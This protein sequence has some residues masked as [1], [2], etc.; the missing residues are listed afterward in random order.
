[1]ASPPA[2][3]LPVTYFPTPADL[4]SWFEEHHATVPELWIGFYNKAS[5]RGGIAYLE[6]LEEALCFGWIDGIKKKVDAASFTLRFTPRKPRSPWSASNLQR[7]EELLRAERIRPP[8]LAAFERRDRNAAPPPA[9]TELAPPYAAKLAENEAA[10]RFF[11]AQPPGYRKNAS[12]WVMSAKKEETRWKRLA[13]LLESAERGVRMP[14]LT[15]QAVSRKP[16]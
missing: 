3:S 14:Q 5:G 4:R 8:G 16:S 2:V 10:Q 13:I 12:L 1:M 6:A 9:V 11:A 15:G 7:M